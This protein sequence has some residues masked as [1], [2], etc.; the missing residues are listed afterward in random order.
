MKKHVDENIIN[1]FVEWCRGVL[2]EAGYS[3]DSHVEELTPIYLLSRQ[4]DENVRKVL[5]MRCFIRELSPLEKRVFVLE[6]LEKNRHYPFWNIG[7][8]NQREKD[9]L[10]M[11]LLEKAKSFMRYEA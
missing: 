8:L 6:V 7:I 11:R 1:G 4:K 9:E 3:P 10:S 2:L 5:E